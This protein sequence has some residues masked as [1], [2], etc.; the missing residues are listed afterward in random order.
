M[1]VFDHRL[2]LAVA[3][4][5]FAILVPAYAQGPS[6]KN[7]S[8]PFND[9]QTRAIEG[10]IRDYIVKHPDILLDAQSA[11]DAQAETRRVDVIRKVLAENK[12][13][14]YHDAD[15]PFIGNPKGDV[16]V[17][18]FFDYNCPYCRKASADIAKLIAG[19]P[20][21]KIVFQEFPNLGADSETVS[22]IVVAAKRQGK[23]YALHRALLDSKGPANEARAL[24]IAGKLGLD[25]SRLKQDATLEDVQNV[26][27]KA[28]AL[29]A[30]LSIEGTPMFL[31]GDR[32][33]QGM[34]ENFYEEL[35]KRISE[36]RAEGCKVC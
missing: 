22:K 29:A 31:I 25:V 17:V 30:K 12:T 23:Y 35:T 26:V 6:G 34:P 8:N 18:E 16:V 3:A 14:I 32:Y 9:A 2:A 4:V 20:N 13:A 5:G 7:E 36:V 21:V 33:I 19:D 28:R 10:M 11:L 1:L 24:E 27:A 15:L